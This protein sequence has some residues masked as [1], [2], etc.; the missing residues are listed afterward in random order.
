MINTELLDAKIEESG[1]RPAKIAE[2]AGIN[3]KN[4][5]LKITN[6]R[7]FKVNEVEKLCEILHITDPV[8]VS[9]IFFAKFDEKGKNKNTRCS[10][11]RKASV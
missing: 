5:R 6:K 9:K 8:E 1:Y 11:E 7:P 4:L 10:V 2:W 3:Y